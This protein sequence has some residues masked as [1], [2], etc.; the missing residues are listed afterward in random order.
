MVTGGS[1]AG[2][3]VVTEG[4]KPKPSCSNPINST[5]LNRFLV[6]GAVKLLRFRP[7]W[8]SV[9]FLTPQ[10]CVKIGECTDL[11]EA[12]TMQFV[13]KHTTLHFGGEARHTL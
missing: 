2:T 5:R 11:S 12:A 7:C 4:T 13:R 3:T 9:L 10:L 8:G 6:L 1:A